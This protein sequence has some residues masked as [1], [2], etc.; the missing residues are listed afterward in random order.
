MEAPSLPPAEIVHPAAPGRPRCLAAGVMA[1]EG[2]ARVR[3]CK[4][5]SSTREGRANIS[6]RP[7]L[8]HPIRITSKPAGSSRHS[9]G[10]SPQPPFAIFSNSHLPMKTKS[11]TSALASDPHVESEL[12]SL[13]S[14]NSIPHRLFFSSCRQ[15][16]PTST[17]PPKLDIPRTACPSRSPPTLRPTLHPASALHWRNGTPV[18][19]TSLSPGQICVTPRPSYTPPPSIIKGLG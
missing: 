2:R 8:P 1:C 4:Y 15:A 17:P 9:T 19:A 6:R 14:N 3:Y 11:Q 16:D 5:T 10:W 12:I 13:S 18:T 7:R